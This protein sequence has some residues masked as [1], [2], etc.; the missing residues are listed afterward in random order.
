M[1][2]WWDSLS[3]MEMIYWGFAIVSSIFFV[4]I[5]I[6]SFLGGDMDSDVGG[7]DADIDADTGIGFQFFSFKNLVGFITLF[8]WSGLAMLE[9]GYSYSATLAVSVLCGLIMMALMATMFYFLSKM[10][11]SGT[12]KISSA[13]GSI[14]ETYLPIGPSRSSMGKI[15]ITVQGGLRTLD[16]LTDNEQEI[17]RGT[18]VE[19]TEVISGDILIVNTLKK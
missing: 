2:E 3:K 7:V 1:A 11:A 13:V 18:M 15:Q 10:T 17:S 12:M 19:V 9:G 8:S 4:F 6:T 14:G 16:A 5:L